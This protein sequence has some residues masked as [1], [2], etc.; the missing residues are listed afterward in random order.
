MAVPAALTAIR[1]AAALA[2][3]NVLL[4]LGRDTSADEIDYVLKVIPKQVDK[5]RAMSPSW[6]TRKK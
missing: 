4:S 3:G 5:L 1:L 2:K 6:D